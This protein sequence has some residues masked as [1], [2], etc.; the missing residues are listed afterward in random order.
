MEVQKTLNLREFL[1]PFLVEWP[2][3][4]NL[5]KT[6][7]EINRLIAHLDDLALGYEAK[8]GIGQLEA[9][10]ASGNPELAGKFQRQ[11]DKLAEAMDAKDIPSIR[12]LVDGFRRAYSAL[13]QSAVGMGRKPEDPVVFFYKCGSMVYKVVRTV[14]DARNVEKEDGVHVVSCQELINMYNKD[15][16][17]VF[18]DREPNTM[19]ID[20]TDAQGFDWINGDVLP[21][22]F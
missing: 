16:V 17:K 1:K 3:T 15:F 20:A 9:W 11:L 14:I 12:G 19:A 5:D 4:D 18:I 22:E 6:N 7:F 13:E 10:A 8:W 21:P 2:M